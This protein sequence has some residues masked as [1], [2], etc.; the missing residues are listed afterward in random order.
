MGGG[1]RCFDRSSIVAERSRF[2]KDPYGHKFEIQ[3]KSVGF[4][5]WKC[6]PIPGLSRSVFKFVQLLKIVGYEALKKSNEYFFKINFY[7]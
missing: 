4:S 1:D 2:M 5:R 3:A 7:L 6:L